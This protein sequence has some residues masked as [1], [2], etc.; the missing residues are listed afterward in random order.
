MFAAL[1][2]FGVAL[3]LLADWAETLLAEPGILPID[4]VRR[5]SHTLFGC[6]AARV[7]DRLLDIQGNRELAR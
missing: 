2:F 5:D 3:H 6:S 4:A 1:L 7:V